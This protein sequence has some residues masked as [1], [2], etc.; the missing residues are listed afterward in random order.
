MAGN[1]QI[2]VVK[3]VLDKDDYGSLLFTDQE[4]KAYKIGVK[5]VHLFNQIIEGR[6]V[7]LFWDTYKGKM[8]IA[9]ARLV[10]PGEPR[11]IPQDS[12]PPESRPSIVKPPAQIKPDGKNRSYA[13]SYAKDWAIALLNSP[14]FS[15]K[16]TLSA[17][18]IM[19]TAKAFEG[20]LDTGEIPNSF[21]VREAKKLGAE[22]IE[23][24]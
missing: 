6:A 12:V 8:Y 14:D 10:E 11:P 19:Q 18:S 23:E 5:R 13:L 15:K 21:L 16:E 24:G 9:D 22:V 7:E 20:Y 4:D 3:S 17:R 1:K 2:I